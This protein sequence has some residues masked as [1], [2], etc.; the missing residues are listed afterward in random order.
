MLNRAPGWPRDFGLT[1]AAGLAVSDALEAVGVRRSRLRLKWPNDCLLDGRKVAGVLIRASFVPGATASSG[2]VVVGIGINLVSAPE[3]SFFPASSLTAAGFRDVGL[4]NVRDALTGAFMARLARWEEVGLP[5]LQEE[6]GER[7]HGVGEIVRVA[8]DRDRTIVEE[9]VS[10][11]I[12]QHGALRLRHADGTQRI[13]PA[14]DV[15]PP[16]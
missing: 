14:G 10:L 4:V 12:D 3:D 11:G 1:F 13:V 9:G 16:F 15:L 2:H 5:G 6:L 7:L 8:L